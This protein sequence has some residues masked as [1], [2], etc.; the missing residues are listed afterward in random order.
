MQL[1]GFL[2]EKMSEK[3]SRLKKNKG[4]KKTSK[5]GW[6]LNGVIS[7]VKFSPVFNS[8]VLY[9]NLQITIKLLSASSMNKQF[10]MSTKFYTWIFYT[11]CDVMYKRPK[12]AGTCS[13]K[14]L[15]P[16]SMCC[17]TSLWRVDKKGYFR[18][19]YKIKIN[20]IFILDINIK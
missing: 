7:Q 4:K 3:K 15:Q 11:S 13:Q 1:Y 6:L 5:K 17:L 20:Q 14:L 16:K 2:L 10:L 19:V 12:T 8:G 18:L 9:A